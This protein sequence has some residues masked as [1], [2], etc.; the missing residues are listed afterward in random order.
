MSS[1]SSAPSI[2]G[3]SMGVNAVLEYYRQN[4]EKVAGM[5]LANGTP[6][7]PLETLFRNN[8]TQG[9]FKI[10]KKAYQTS[11]ELVQTA[12]KL[13]KGSQFMRT[14]ITLGG[15]N[16]H[17]TPPEDVALYVDQVAE[18][19]PAVFIHLIE[20]YDNVDSTSWL[21]TI[22][23]PSLIIG[24]EEDRLVPIE[25]QELMHQLIPGSRLEKIRHGSHCSQ[26]DL[27]DLVN[28]KIE[29]FLS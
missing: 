23:V 26:M 8:A 17:L 19:D 25:L 10:L 4:P 29:R 1:V 3:H 16:P 9:A 2:L 12:W 18:M 15:F 21:H 28:L 27:P 7:R 20:N 14:L 11:P 22:K 6:R 13:G 5:V 24:G